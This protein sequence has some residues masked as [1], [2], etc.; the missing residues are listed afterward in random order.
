[1]GLTGSRQSQVPGVLGSRMR[2]PDCEATEPVVQAKFWEPGFIECAVI[3]GEKYLRQGLFF[4]FLFFFF[5]A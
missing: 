3:L 4:L 5:S 1:M 2:D